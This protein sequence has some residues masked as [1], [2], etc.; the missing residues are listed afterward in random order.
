MFDASFFGVPPREAAVMDPQHRVVLELAWS[1][2]ESAGYDPKDCP[3]TI[4]LWVGASEPTY[5]CQN[6]LCRPD[7]VEKIGF[8]R[9]TM[10]NGRDYLA[11]RVSYKL[12]LRGPSV[13]L[14]AE[15]ATSLVAVSE[16]FSA[17]VGNRCD[18]ALA[19]GVCIRSPLRGSC[20]QVVGGVCARD[21]RCKP[22]DARADGSVPGD[23]A[24]IFVL[25]RIEDAYADAD[26]IWAI[27]RGV[28]VNNDGFMRESREVTTVRGL[29]ETMAMAQAVAGVEPES[30]S[31]I[32]ADGSGC[33][34][35]DAAEIEALRGVFES[36]KREGRE[37]V[38]GSVKGNIGHLDAASGA[39][40]LMKTVLA[41]HREQI[42]PTLHFEKPASGS[43]L[44][45]G[46][47]AVTTMPRAW[48]S[49]GAP[50]RAGVSAIGRC[51]TNAHVVLEEAPKSLRTPAPVRDQLLVLSARSKP[52]LE[53]LA[54]NL[55]AHLENHPE[56][57]LAGAAHTLQVG[58]RAFPYRR[59]VVCRDTKEAVELLRGK[60]PARGQAAQETNEK[61]S[62]A[63]LFPGQGAQY[64]GM[65]AELYA[66]EPVFAAEFDACSDVLDPL[67]GCSL[68]KLVFAS[69]ANREEAEKR[70]AETS[71]TQPALFA[72]EL[73]LARLWMSW[74]IEPDVMI[75]H[76]LGE[77]VAAC[78]AE[79][80]PRHT[81]LSVVAARAR[82]MQ[83]QPR[84]AMMAVRLT[85]SELAPWITPEIVVAAANAPTAQVVSGAS[86]AISELQGEMSERGIAC[87]ILAT[88]HAFHSPMMEGALPEFRCVLEESAL[89]AP[90]R[91]W[92]SCL[93][94]ARITPAQATDPEYWVQQLRQTV[95]FSTGIHRLMTSP[96]MALLEVGP[97]QTLVGLVR[98]H[99]ERP[100]QQ[101]LLNSL[102]RA[103]GGDRRC[104]LGALGALWTT[105]FAPDWESVRA[106]VPIQRVPL[107]TYPFERVRYWL[108]PKQEEEER[109]VESVRWEGG[110][111]PGAEGGANARQ[112][113]SPHAGVVE[114]IWK[115]LLGVPSIHAHDIF[116]D[117]GGDSLLAIQMVAQIKQH[118]GH[119][120]PVRD[121]M[122]QT[123][124]QL[125]ERVS[126]SR[127]NPSKDERVS[128]SVGSATDLRPQNASL[129]SHRACEGREMPMFFGQPALFGTYHPPTGAPAG[130]AL[131]V[132]ICPPI[133]HEHTRAHRAIRTLAR[134]L[135]RAGHPALRF[136]YRGM[137][138]SWGY[139]TDGGA[140]A[141]C[142]DVAGAIKELASLSGVRRMGLV[143]TRVGALLAVATMAS[144]RARGYAIEHLVL[145]DPVLCGEQF[146][147][148]AGALDSQFLNDPGRF[149]WIARAELPLPPR[150]SGDSLVGYA[151]P[152]EIRRSLRSLDL[153]TMK[154]WPK[155]PTSVLLSEP[156]HECAKL[157]EK[158]G[159]E[160]IAAEARVE[161][162]AEGDWDNYQ[163]H[164]RALQAGPM[165]SAI[166]ACLSGRAR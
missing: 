125:E 40:G 33:P 87:R 148:T 19:G 114:K 29:A 116:F 157:I 161:E 39:A 86:P 101:L 53:N 76:S 110:A 25:K 22:F 138:E 128:V 82:L 132:L 97:G 129:G 130:T 57:A 26:F 140:E 115:D 122:M 139:P 131:A 99:T 136:D 80:M 147:R 85:A 56:V 123:L 127:R 43:G 155:V 165:A 21:G 90:T 119:D 84:G 69:E 164:E 31:Y 142:D 73:A 70:L 7:A 35:N 103:P 16:A 52:A 74:G 88:S 11:T 106:R 104:M 67:L 28:A 94:G 34:P 96:H 72:V 46:R 9:A 51:G 15:E 141:W 20:V 6:V 107:P 105:G 47:F 135:A 14:F 36:E 117:L 63:F 65:A 54:Q 61:P 143:G 5:Y 1:A 91:P 150:E 75:G 48:P 77:Y 30:I 81:A 113:P 93:T 98:M 62:V 124:E 89:R 121:V 92:I 4:G 12:G 23:G 144:E 27:L 2:L 152:P 159:V 24:G 149:S 59:A 79:V 160:G 156:S 154:A 108:S 37:C 145:W 120:I 3:G 55:A 146:L 45:E 60:Q 41:L 112:D 153:R 162:R 83:A 109:L 100:M 10:G 126:A 8:L 118:A 78:V 68:R 18:M 133:G 50:R 44:S 17:L 163:R 95:R 66:Q 166:V 111:P 71:V 137:G 151:F 158:L 49:G 64:V 42:P 38:L 58:R 13:G 134:S 32:E 102:G